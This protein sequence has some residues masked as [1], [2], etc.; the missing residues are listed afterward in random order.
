MKPSGK[1]QEDIMRSGLFAVLAALV[2]AGCATT[3]E[4]G[5]GTFKLRLV[6]RSDEVLQE[7]I[8]RDADTELKTFTDMHTPG[9]DRVIEDCPI[10]LNKPFGLLCYANGQ[11]V[12]HVLS[13]NMYSP[14]KNRIETFCFTYLGGNEWS[15]AARDAAGKEVKFDRGA[16]ERGDAKSQVDLGVCYLSGSGVA[17]DYKEAV[18]WFRKAAQQGNADGQYRLGVCYYTGVGAPENHEEALKWLHKSAKQGN[19][20]AKDFLEKVSE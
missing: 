1:E 2:L 20:S 7:V 11:R 9:G 18:K 13:L 19:A 14:L 4:D 17:T 3:S 5:R 15:V 6:N 8:V 12:S 16:A 10:N